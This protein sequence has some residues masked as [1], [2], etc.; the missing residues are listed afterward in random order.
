[1]NDILSVSITPANQVT[2]IVGQSL[3]LAAVASGGSGSYTS[4]QWYVD[5]TLQSEATTS[6]FTYSPGSSTG[7]HSIT[8]TVTDSLGTTSDSI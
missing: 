6:S 8:V 5:S 2:V 1:M 4:Y 3:T 7:M